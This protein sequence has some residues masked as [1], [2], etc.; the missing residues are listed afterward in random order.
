MTRCIGTHRA[1]E[2][3][4]PRPV[5][6]AALA[7]AVSIAASA[8][9]RTAS[10]AASVPREP[11]LVE[12]YRFPMDFKHFYDYEDMAATLERV[13]DAFPD[14]TE[15]RSIGRSREG[16]DLWMLRVT[17]EKVGTPDEKP[18]IYVDGNIHGNE[19]QA[20]EVCLYVIHELVNRVGRDELVTRLLDERTFYIVPTVNPDS[21]ARFFAE[22]N[23]PHSPRS[24]VRPRDDD[25]DGL[26]DEDG[27]EDLNG[28]G[29]ITLMRKHDP[30]GAYK[31]GEDLRSLVARELDENGE[32][33]LY[34]YEGLDN[35]GDGRINE[36]SRGGVDLNRNFPADWQPEATQSGAGP[37]PG[38][39][40]EI[41]AIIEFIHDRPNIAALQ[42][43][44]NVGNLILY[45]FGARSAEDLPGRDRRVYEIM[46]ERGR[47]ILTDYD[48]GSIRDDLYHV[49]GTTVAFG[50]LHH[51]AVSFSNE[52]WSWVVDY[53]GDGTITMSERLKWSDERLGGDAFVEWTPFQHPELGEIEI[54]GWT[55][56]HSRVPPVGYLAEMCRLNADFVLFHAD[57]MPRLSIT[58]SETSA[59]GDGTIA[60]DVFVANTGIMDSYPEISAQLGIARPVVATVS[61]AGGA[62]ALDGYVRPREHARVTRTFDPVD[63]RTPD[64]ARVEVGQIHGGQ[65]IAI[66]W[67]LEAPAG[68]R[69]TVRIAGDKCGRAEAVV[70]LEP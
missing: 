56:F 57:A 30:F 40:P 67:L 17:N 25:R 18:A 45:P 58:R 49:Y 32:W 20:T 4:I 14:L 16:R 26:V 31:T 6:I 42:T 62:R 1:R 66:R 51:G 63:R 69:A 8:I 23:T 29:V 39:E 12:P 2:H 22:P 11:S 64:P 21:R 43:F 34:W 33:T 65:E 53:D 10:S 46:A 38:S 60:L 24:N 3:H 44:H 37:Y 9:D 50:Y 13:A 41:R 61:V 68:S 47:E 27:P 52:L 28:D 48:P 70:T 35:D 36:D 55:Q 59:L 15:L 7:L 5:A 54:G 19:I